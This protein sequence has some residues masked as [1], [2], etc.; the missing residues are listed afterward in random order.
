[1]ANPIF[2]GLFLIYAFLTSGTTEAAGCEA[3]QLP[4]CSGMKYNMTQ[5]PNLLHHSA[6]ENAKLSIEQFQDLVNTNCSDLLLFFLC[7]MYAP[8]C[9]KSLEFEVEAIPPCKGVCVEARSKC[10][11]TMLRYNVTWPDYLSCQNLPEYTRGVC[12]T[13]EA[14]VDTMP[15]EEKDLSTDQPSKPKRTGKS[16]RGCENNKISQGIFIEKAYEYVVRAT[17]ESFVI[18]GENLMYTTI[19]VNDVLKFTDINIPIG[20][21]HL[22]TKNSCVCPRVTPGLEYVIMCY[23]D[24]ENGR[25]RLQEDCVAQEWDDDS[26]WPRLVKKWN[27]KLRKAERLSSERTKPTSP[28]SSSSKRR[29]RSR[30]VPTEA[31]AP[32]SDRRGRGRSRYESE[33]ESVSDIP[34]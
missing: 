21:V 1:M 5:M 23:Q 4:M 31:E 10:E 28:T 26:N 16:C 24:L 20:E 13:P 9:T 34:W 15:D 3:I 29:R 17:V 7:T 30:P 27:K 14:I 18:V 32:S 33:V 8:I 19:I 25:L 12:L 6:Q 2:G 22:V 11:P